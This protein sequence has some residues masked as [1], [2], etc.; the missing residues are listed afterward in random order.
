M[1]LVNGLDGVEVVNTGIETDLVHDGDASLLSLGV[2]LSHGRRDVTCGNDMLLVADGG[3]DDSSVV[4]VG[5]QADGQVVLG[6]LLIES[7]GIRDVERD[8]VGV[9]NA[10]GKLLGGG[11]GSASWR[12]VSGSAWPRGNIALYLRYLPTVTETPA[13][14]KMSRVGLV[15]K[16]A[17]SINTD[18]PEAMILRY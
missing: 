9:G 7:L 3:L 13:S 15:T 5:D 16:P 4:C 6:D 18:F 2:Q 12:K 1:D 8:R 11:L 14:L 10:L 17:P